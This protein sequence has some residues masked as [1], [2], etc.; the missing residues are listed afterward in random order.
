M[1]LFFFFVWFSSRLKTSC[2]PCLVFCRCLKFSA[3]ILYKKAAHRNYEG[4]CFCSVTVLRSVTLKNLH[5]QDVKNY[6]VLNCLLE[7]LCQKK[8]SIDSDCVFA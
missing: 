4:I 2:Q 8:K 6:L 5:V 1:S 7:V 3:C